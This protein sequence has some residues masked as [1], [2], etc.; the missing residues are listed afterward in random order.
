MFF[1]LILMK[2]Y[3]VIFLWTQNTFRS[4]YISTQVVHEYRASKSSVL[5]VLCVLL[6]CRKT[7]TFDSRGNSSRGYLDLF[8]LR[9]I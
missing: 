3:E 5:P 7:P 9:L 8:A 4:I 1:D 2:K 6:V